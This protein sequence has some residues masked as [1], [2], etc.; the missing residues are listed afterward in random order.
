MGCQAEDERSDNHGRTC[1]SLESEGVLEDTQSLS[2]HHVVRRFSCR[3]DVPFLFFRDNLTK[4][5]AHVPQPGLVCP[6]SAAPQGCCLWRLLFQG[7]DMGEERDTYTCGRRF[8]HRTVSLV[9]FALAVS[10]GD[11]GMDMSAVTSAQPSPPPE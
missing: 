10:T 8:V 9:C 7:E 4:D 2:H 3:G 11:N 1:A 6:E 5:I